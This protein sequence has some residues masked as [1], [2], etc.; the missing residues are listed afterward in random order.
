MSWVFATEFADGVHVRT[1]C[2][3]VLHA[4]TSGA[5]LA[6][7][8]DPQE[9]AHGGRWGDGDAFQR[10]AEGRHAERLPGRLG[11]ALR[12]SRLRS[13]RPLSRSTLNCSS[14][15]AMAAGRRRAIE[16]EART[17]EW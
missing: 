5:R 4:E 9:D 2:T 11:T 17:R 7:S 10:F 14:S 13:R 3:D 8:Y 6:S 16:H 15:S 1:R 12:S